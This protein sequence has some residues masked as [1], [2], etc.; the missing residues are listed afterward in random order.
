MSQILAMTQ[1]IQEIEQASGHFEDE[2]M[3]ASIPADRHLQEQS[4]PSAY[5]SVQPQDV[6]VAHDALPLQFCTP[7]Q[8]T[9]AVQEPTQS[10]DNLTPAPNQE[11]RAPAMTS[12]Q[13]AEWHERALEACSHQLRLPVETVR[14][15]LTTYWSWVFPAFMFVSRPQFLK[16]TSTGGKYSSP[17]LIAVM[18]LHATRLTDHARAEDLHSHVRYMLGREIHSTP[19]IPLVQAL[20]QLSARELGNGS[21]H[22][23]WL[24]SGMAFRLATDMGI[25]TAATSPAA[26]ATEAHVRGQL[27]WSCY[28]WDK[29]VSLY[30]GRTPSLPE[31]PNFEPSIL[32]ES[33]EEEIW[34]PVHSNAGAVAFSA[35]THGISCF[36]NFCKLGV[37][38]QDVLATIYAM[39][40]NTDIVAFVQHARNRLEAWRA[41]SPP[42]LTASA[43]SSLCPPPHI[44]SQKY[45]HYH[46]FVRRGQH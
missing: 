9:S 11:V 28:L 38:I 21:L 46:V 4:L 18:C 44:L 37:I 14:H 2:Q 30:L 15:L 36:K 20:L 29:A 33:I 45:G 34:N 8:S 31:S 35:Q 41:N 5:H 23:A 1:R 27:A 10:V 7:F 22:Q 26:D 24:Y 39:K 19:S 3:A 42:H 43:T 16:D 6:N 40:P 17:L 25:M 13:L 12:Y 32:D